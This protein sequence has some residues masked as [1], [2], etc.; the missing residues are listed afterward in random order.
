MISII[1]Y[2]YYII[3]RFPKNLDD[4]GFW[5]MTLIELIFGVEIVLG[6]FL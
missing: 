4:K 5:L 1:V 6:F 3:A 2:P